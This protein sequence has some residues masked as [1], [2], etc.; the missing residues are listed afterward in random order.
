[1]SFQDFI[2]DTVEDCVKHRINNNRD[3]TALD[4]FELQL[5][6]QIAE[7]RYNNDTFWKIVDAIEE[8]VE[9]WEDVL[10]RDNFERGAVRNVDD[11]IDCLMADTLIKSRALD[12]LNDNDYYF[13]E[14]TANSD[15]YKLL[16]ESRGRSRG[17]RDSGYRDDRGGRGAMRDT[18][19]R[20]SRDMRDAPRR[21]S[22]DMRG[23]RPGVSGLRE[24]VRD[25][26]HKAKRAASS[27]NAFVHAARIREQDVYVTEEIDDAPRRTRSR[28]DEPQRGRVPGEERV[29]AEAPV[30]SRTSGKA[31][32]LNP[33]PAANQGYDHTSEAPYEEFW[34]DDCLWQASV[35]SDW[36][37][38]G[39]GA[40]S[41]LRLYNIYKYVSYYVMDEFGNVTQRFKEVTNENRYLNQSLLKDPD[42]YK[43][44]FGRKPPKLSQL[45]RGNVDTAEVNSVPEVDTGVGYE[46][47]DMIDLNQSDLDEAYTMI[48]SENLSTS[49]IEARM[50]LSKEDRSSSL[51][52][53][54]LMDP[55]EAVSV[56]EASMIKDLY[57]VNTLMSLSKNLE[58]LRGKISNANFNR[59]NSKIS[60]YLI[61]MLKNTFGVP[62]KKLEF[63]SDWPTVIKGLV[64]RYGQEWVDTF[65]RRAN[66]LIPTILSIVDVA[67]ED[68]NID[69][70]FENIVTE[71]NKDRIVP[72]VDFYAMV[73]INCTLDQLSIGR[74]IELESPLILRAM[75]D[76]YSTSALI[77]VL[78][79]VDEIRE[80]VTVSR[81]LLSTT[82]GALVEVTRHELLNSNIV[83]SMFTPR[84]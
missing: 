14:D 78:S 1:M 5:M 51:N 59:I 52:I 60:D 84:K 53:F 20:D 82:C 19:R 39:E 8:R 42:S 29:A 45:M 23:S 44:N 16:F 30:R 77:S 24:P 64:K 56:S 32:V 21:D 61:D 50:R 72:Y 4:H 57:S 49:A 6:D 34:E 17:R 80:A 18:P 9:E 3:R 47:E 43:S 73:S 41:Y 74:Q 71:H 79:A 63:A 67:D 22:R 46:L 81:I 27:N 26:A 65:A 2:A 70:V 58:G 13:I 75:D 83:L 38:T 76:I 33:P 12:Q 36:E 28:D 66:S 15:V 31:R 11:F 62:L 37:V 68:G 7:N 55:I 69:P 54:M 25:M 40:D 10:L 48:P 35:K